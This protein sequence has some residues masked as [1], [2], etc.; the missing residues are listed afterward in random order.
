MTARPHPLPLPERPAAI[1]H[2]CFEAWR[3]AASRLPAVYCWHTHTIARSI[4][5]GWKLT[6]NALANDVAAL[7]AAGIL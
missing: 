5:R 3:L 7:R 6:P 4:D 1:C 2:A